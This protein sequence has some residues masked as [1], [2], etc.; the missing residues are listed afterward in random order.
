MD[1]IGGTP[2]EARQKFLTLSGAGER[3]QNIA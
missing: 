1:Y 2:F 3:I